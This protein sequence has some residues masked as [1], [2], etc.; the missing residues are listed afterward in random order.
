MLAGMEFADVVRRRRMVRN[1]D[2]RPVDP[3]VVERILDNA[4]HAPSAGFSQGWGFLVLDQPAAVE[5]FWAAT[6]PEGA[7]TDS[8][9]QGLRRAPVL[10]VPLSCKR[11]Y[12][13]RYA[14]PD[15]GWTDQDESRWPV[16]YWHIDTGMAALLMLLTVTDEGLGACF[17]G[18]PPE[19]IPA[20]RTEFGVPEDH[21]PIGVV[22][23]GHRAPDRR[24][25]SLRRGRRGAEQVVHRGRW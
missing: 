12:L 4:L 21:Q 15:K 14:E 9:S 23:L 24:S 6:T 18:I 8:W 22:A 20:F 2:P 16:P 1:F 17:F 7:G 19:R 13:E 11:A 10:V 3:A 25:P 5:R